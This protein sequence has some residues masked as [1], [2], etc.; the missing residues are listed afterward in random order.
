MTVSHAWL[1]VNVVVCRSCI[2]F[3]CVRGSK[4]KHKIR[5]HVVNGVRLR[6]EGFHGI[7]TVG[8]PFFSHSARPAVPSTKHLELDV[9]CVS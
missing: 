9:F 8:I 3:G 7:L 1:S 6:W 4:T 2:V 5:P